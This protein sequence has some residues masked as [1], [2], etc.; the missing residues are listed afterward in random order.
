MSIKEEVLAVLD[1]TLHLEGRTQGFNESTPLLG[2]VPELDSMAVIE[3][4][5]VL[6]ERLGFTTADDDIDGETF[7]TLGSLLAF[8]NSKLA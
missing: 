3:V 1:E 7:S 6:E 2:A 4:L 5:Q 8:V